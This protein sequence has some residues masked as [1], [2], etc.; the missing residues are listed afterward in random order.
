MSKYIIELKQ[1]KIE[2]KVLRELLGKLGYTLIAEDSR[3]ALD[4]QFISFTEGSGKI[5]TVKF[6]T[7][8]KGERVIIKRINIYKG[9]DK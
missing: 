1:G 7:P 2:P 6:D 4:R 8:Y 3:T 5:D 9:E